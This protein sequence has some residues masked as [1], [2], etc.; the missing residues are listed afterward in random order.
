M[1]WKCHLAACTESQCTID[2]NVD[3]TPHTHDT[4]IA[5]RL[6]TW[7]NQTHLKPTWMRVRVWPR[8]V[9][10]IRLQTPKNILDSFVR[11]FFTLVCVAP[12]K[13]YVRTWWDFLL[14]W[15]NEID[16]LWINLL[17]T[18]SNQ[19]SHT[20]TSAHRRIAIC[21]SE[22]GCVWPRRKHAHNVT[23]MC[24]RKDEC[25]STKNTT[26]RKIRSS[27]HRCFYSLHSTGR[28]CRPYA[29]DWLWPVSALKYGCSFC[30]VRGAHT[31][32]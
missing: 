24:R 19:Y 4:L 20:S 22:R 2:T 14:L 21:S 11:L 26:D 6:C 12:N 10:I 13:M 9:R 5:V 16:V 23:R 8:I 28:L 31:R 17:A 29:S 18:T 3:T 7:F 1:K 27:A 32:A 30:S 15:T 25:A